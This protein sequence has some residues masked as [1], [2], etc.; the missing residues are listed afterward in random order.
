MLHQGRSEQSTTQKNIHLASR[1]TTVSGISATLLQGRHWLST[2]NIT[3]GRRRRGFPEQE[4]EKEKKKKTPELQQPLP[5]KKRRRSKLVFGLLLLISRSSLDTYPSPTQI[6][7]DNHLPLRDPRKRDYCCEQKTPPPSSLT[8]AFLGPARQARGQVGCEFR[9]E[10]VF[11]CHF[12]CAGQVKVFPGEQSGV[13]GSSIPFGL[14]IRKGADG[15]GLG[16]E[17]GW[18]GTK[19]GG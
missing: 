10:G 2:R 13:V 8:S 18:Q 3:Q 14:W 12:C 19:K 1:G 11:A 17:R 9:G 4:G 7:D 5:L 15:S 16:W 6:D